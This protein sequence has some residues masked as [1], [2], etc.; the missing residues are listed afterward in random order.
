M[1]LKN[2]FEKLKGDFTAKRNAF[3]E[4]KR[5]D[6]IAEIKRLRKLRAKQNLDKG[7]KSKAAKLREQ[8]G[9]QKLSEKAGKLLDKAT[10]ASKSGKSKPA[11]VSLFED[12]PRKKKSGL[13]LTDDKKGG[14][15]LTL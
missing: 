4:T 7:L 2:K 12:K 3:K 6:T 8:T 14:G 5:K 1:G 10:K 11:N 15:G 9:K 13:S